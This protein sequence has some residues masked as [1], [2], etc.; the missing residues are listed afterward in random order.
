MD[1]F[2]MLDYNSDYAEFLSFGLSPQGRELKYLL[3]SKEYE[4]LNRSVRKES[5]NPTLFIINGIH[6]GEIEG[7]DASMILMRE[8]LITKEK[9]YYLIV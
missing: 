5:I 1:Y 7:K 6:S 9:E 8:I 2:Q 3:V 4:I